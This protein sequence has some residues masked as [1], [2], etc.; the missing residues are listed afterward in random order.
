MPNSR[1][2]SFVK[3]CKETTSIFKEISPN[4]LADPSFSSELAPLTSGSVMYCST[5]D[6]PLPPPGLS[7]EVKPLT[8][9]R[10]NLYSSA[11]FKSYRSIVVT[12]MC[13]NSVKISIGNV[14]FP[15][16]PRR[17]VDLGTINQPCIILNMYTCKVHIQFLL[18]NIRN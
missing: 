16:M 1:A 8:F 17:V 13:S 11:L 18:H 4:D 12:N 3:V 5:F 2:Y 6:G 7:P 14:E 15:Q 10:C 9:C